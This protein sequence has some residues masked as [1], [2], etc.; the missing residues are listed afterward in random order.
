MKRFNFSLAVILLILFFNSFNS[1]SQWVQTNGPYGDNISSITASL[2]N[3]Y[4]G[5]AGFYSANYNGINW[6]RLDTALTNI[7]V[8]ALELKGT[9]LFAGTSGGL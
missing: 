5:T 6:I 2:F 1:F 4:V 9:K 8:T 3:L 7:E